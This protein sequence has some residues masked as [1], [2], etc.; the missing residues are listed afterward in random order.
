MSTVM[1]NE[2]NKYLDE[3]CEL[4][5]NK[6]VHEGIRE[7]ITSH[8]EELT[9][10]YMY[11]GLSEEESIRKA[12]EQ[13]GPAEVVGKDL[14]KIHKAAPDWILLGLTSAFISIGLFVLWFIQSNNFLSHGY[15]TNYLSN[16]VIYMAGG[17]IT[18]VVLMKID[19]RALKKYSKYIYIGGVALLLS[20]FLFGNSI[21]GA[22]GWVRVGNMSLN[23]LLVSP[24]IIIISLCGIFEKWDWSSRKKILIGMALVFM[25]SPLFILGRSSVN[26]GIY[27]I[28]A[29]TVM[30][31]S[32]VRVKHVVYAL[33]GLVSFVAVYIFTNPYRIT[34][35]IDRFNPGK[36]SSSY[37][38]IY[39]QIAELNK[40]A[41]FFGQGAQFSQK[42]LPEIHTDFVFTF[43]VYCFGWI[44]GI[45]II[46]LVCA[47]II[48][49]GL[50]GSKVKDKYGKMIVCGFCAL[51]S[52]QFILAILTN[53]NILPIVSLSMPFISYGGSSLVINILSVSVISN[54][55][56]W[57]NTPYKVT[58]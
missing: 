49:I 6:R 27:I 20:T 30:I 35:F 34:R 12:I 42:M 53:L 24:Y 4:V 58:A 36:E 43:I 26:F 5:R 54:V 45:V 52:A 37:S 29:I 14:N 38:W 16:S 11:V 2:I 33:S 50:I 51:I 3:V 23:T 39:A 13:M 7:E 19:Y 56:K 22:L 47:F 17:I 21:N 1:I 46:A 25:P 48:R 28:G 18:A 40:N 9:Q 44:A 55:F 8:I 10:D 41:G 57:R 15:N 31:I 32:G